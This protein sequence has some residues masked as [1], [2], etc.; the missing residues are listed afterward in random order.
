MTFVY[1]AVLAISAA[2][3]FASVLHI[4]K[5]LGGG[6][7][8]NKADG[9]GKGREVFHALIIIAIAGAASYWAW[10]NIN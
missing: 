1:W 10:G 7:Y 6:S 5:V 8:M 9:V 4:L 3:S 2:F